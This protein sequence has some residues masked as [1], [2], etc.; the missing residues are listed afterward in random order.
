M[1]AKIANDEGYT[2]DPVTF[3]VLKNAYVNIVWVWA[4]AVRNRVG[5]QRILRAVDVLAETSDEE[6]K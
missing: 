6:A 4:L 2:L 1:S 3:E 5:E